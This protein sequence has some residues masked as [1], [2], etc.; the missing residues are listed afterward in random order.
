MGKLIEIKT[1]I[2]QG[3]HTMEGIRVRREYRVTARFAG[4]TKRHVVGGQAITIID[5]RRGTGIS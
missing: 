5:T 1:N 3:G 2:Y 4:D